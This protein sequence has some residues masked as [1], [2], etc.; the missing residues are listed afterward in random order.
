MPRNSWRWLKHHAGRSIWKPGSVARTSR[1]CPGRISFARAAVRITGWGQKRPVQSN[2]TSAVN[3]LALNALPTPQT[4]A[5]LA[6]MRALDALIFAAAR[7]ANLGPHGAVIL[8]WSGDQHDLFSIIRCE[9]IFYGRALDLPRAV[10][11]PQQD[12]AQHT[13]LQLVGVSRQL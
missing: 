5:H 8:Q 6:T 11:V 4:P 10:L 2:V 1:V 7:A 13:R 9:P 12:A 3:A